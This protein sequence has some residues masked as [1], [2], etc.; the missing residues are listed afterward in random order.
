MF[1]TLDGDKDKDPPQVCG[2]QDCNDADPLRANGLA[3]VCDGKDNDCDGTKDEQDASNLC[4]DT[5]SCL[6]G[7]CGCAAGLTECDSACR[8]SAWFADNE[9]HC[10]ACGF[11]CEA[12]GAECIQG[13]CSCGSTQNPC[14]VGTCS[15][16]LS[17][18]A[19]DCPA[20]FVGGLT[21]ED[22]DECDSNTCSGYP[23]I[24]ET[25]SFHCACPV[26]YEQKVVAGDTRCLDINECLN[27]P[28]A[29]GTCTNAPGGSFSCTCPTGYTG[30]Q[31]CGDIN[32]CDN[33]SYCGPQGICANAVGGVTC[34]CEAPYVRTASVCSR[35]AVQLD[36]AY[37]HVCAVLDNGALRCWGDNSFGKVPSEQPVRLG[38]GRTAKLVATGF[39]HT[40]VL[41][42]NNTFKCWGYNDHG[43]L[44]YGDTKNRSTPADMG[45]ALPVVPL[46]AGRSG[47]G[48]SAYLATYFLLDDGTG[49]WAERH[50]H[51]DQRGVDQRGQWLVVRATEEQPGLLRGRPGQRSVERDG[52]WN[53]GAWSRAHRT[54]SQLR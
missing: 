29:P 51:P 44:G 27:S 4:R 12:P 37:Q 54:P 39:H 52:Q 22:I 35:K 30:S 7:Q 15:N 47:A 5:Y 46:P 1:D 11:A 34:T 14:G 28:C 42:D 41:L 6:G 26:G 13:V 43:Q 49:T 23:C 40:C 33:P 25:G 19:C 17:G 16:S 8:D 45:D 10:G 31:A 32:E 38:A 48:V 18:Y 21:C 36:V 53:R 20:G 9:Q 3:E 2:G 50:H 24:N